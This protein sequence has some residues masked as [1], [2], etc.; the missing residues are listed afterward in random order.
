[1]RRDLDKTLAEVAAA[2]GRQLR[3][4]PQEL[5]IIALIMEQMDQKPDLKAVY[6]KTEDPMDRVKLSAEL[7]LLQGSIERLLRRVEVKMPTPISRRSEK[8]RAAAN[9]RWALEA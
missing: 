7:R 3:W 1:L 5:T 4:S 2:S 6:A 8:A 9:A